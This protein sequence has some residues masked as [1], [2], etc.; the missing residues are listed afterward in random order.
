MI[1]IQHLHHWAGT[2][3][4]RMQ[5]TRL[6][7]D[8]TIIHERQT[9]KFGEFIGSNLN[10]CFGWDSCIRRW[11][12]TLSHWCLRKRLFDC[13]TAHPG[14]AAEDLSNYKSNQL[15]INYKYKLAFAIT[16]PKEEHISNMFLCQSILSERTGV[17]RKGFRVWGFFCVCGWVFERFN[18]WKAKLQS[19]KNEK[20]S[21]QSRWYL[22]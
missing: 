12:Y 13:W 9:T 20:S 10:C 16:F 6:Q 11:E 21:G 19:G 2:Q 8:H 3:R 17:L 18:P 22:A 5:T 15:Q 14:Y 4:S 7:H 1:Q